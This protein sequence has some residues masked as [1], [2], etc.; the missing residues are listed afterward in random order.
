MQTYKR[1][2]QAYFQKVRKSFKFERYCRLGMLSC[3]Q[4]GWLPLGKPTPL[5]H[6]TDCKTTQTAKS[7]MA[8]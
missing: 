1:L 4:F 2:M 7:K 5:Q 8:N 6:R 3:F